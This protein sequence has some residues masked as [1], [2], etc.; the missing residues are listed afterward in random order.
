MKRLNVFSLTKATVL[1][2]CTWWC[3]RVEGQDSVYGPHFGIMRAIGIGRGPGIHAYNCCQNGQCGSPLHGYAPRYLPYGP[4]PHEIDQRLMHAGSAAPQLHYASH[5][6]LPPQMVPATGG[7][8]FA[9]PPLPS[10]SRAQGARQASQDPPEEVR[11]EA[12]SEEDEKSVAK[13]S[14][15]PSDAQL[16]HGS[17]DLEQNAGQELE[18]NNEADNP[19]QAL[20]G[21]EDLQSMERDAQDE[22]SSFSDSPGDAEDDAYSLPEKFDT[23]EPAGALGAFDLPELPAPEM[24]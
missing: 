18:E 1:V 14:P 16:D 19:D 22:N 4:A 24:Q 17:D 8:P 7:S 10:P 21:R 11:G 12:A 2:A 3:G 13:A 23:L 15:S 6:G 5:G 20:E 9:P